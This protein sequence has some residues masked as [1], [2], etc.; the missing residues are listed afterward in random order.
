MHAYLP[1]IDVLMC[2]CGISFEEACEQLG[3]NMAEL[4]ESD[5]REKYLQVSEK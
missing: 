5:S 2:H 1:A 4:T 3:V